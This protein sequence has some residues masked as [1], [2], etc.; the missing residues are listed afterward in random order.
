MCC[1]DYMFYTI[2]NINI[3]SAISNPV[4]ITLLVGNQ[5]IG[6]VQKQNRL[7]L[8]LY[9]PKTPFGL[10]EI[11]LIAG[12][13][14]QQDLPVSQQRESLSI[15]ADIRGCYRRTDADTVRGR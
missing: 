15:G 3:I 13:F 12:H 4:H 1:S 14:K 8:L 10:T 11:N 2:V 9:K 7:C 6:I 5:H